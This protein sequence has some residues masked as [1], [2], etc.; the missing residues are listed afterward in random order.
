[1]E[2]PNQIFFLIKENLEEARFYL[3]YLDTIGI[4]PT[5]Y[6][7]ILETQLIDGLLYYQLCYHVLLTLHNPFRNVV[8]IENHQHVL[9]RVIVGSSLINFVGS[10]HAPASGQTRNK[11]V[12]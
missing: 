11:R 2:N 10:Q 6:H 1:M 9:L 4:T 8:I 3:L 7:R 12:L 5:T